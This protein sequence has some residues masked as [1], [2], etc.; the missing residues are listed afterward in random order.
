MS[1]RIGKNKN[2]HN[3]TLS[4]FRHIYYTA[5][6]T[7]GQGGKK[8]YHKRRRGIK[9]RENI[10]KGDSMDNIE[11]IMSELKNMDRTQRDALLNTLEQSMSD[12]Q[13]KKL[14]KMLSG[15]SGKQQLEKELSGVDINA[16][17]NGLS[18]KNEL[19]RALSRD[20]IQKKLRDILG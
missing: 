19:S 9:Y 11:K 17:L 20:D 4:K 5:K 16:L 18:D 10:Y 6:Y 2:F 14:K 8:R 1:V 12:S 3:F 13:Q 15:K 7:K